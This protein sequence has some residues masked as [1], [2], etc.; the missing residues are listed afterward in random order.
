MS[1]VPLTRRNV[2]EQIMLNLKAL[3]VD[4]AKYE[5]KVG[6]PG[7]K[8]NQKAAIREAR[9][10]AAYKK[11]SK[12]E[13]KKILAA[14]TQNVD[15]AYYAAQNEFGTQSSP[16][17][18]SR[19]F[20]RTTMERYKE[21]INKAVAAILKEVAN[22][23]RDA[24]FFMDKLGQFVAGMVKLNI[25]DGNWAPNSFFTILRKSKRKYSDKPLIDTG[26][27]RQSITSWTVKK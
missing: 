22:N 4:T 9:K 7:G 8:M 24:H 15:I 19:P 16:R 10:S 12:I 11:A 20:L 27:M 6:I 13:R 26:I 14:A 17:I 3:L 2:E 1:V 18:P 25:T 21:K 23:N 5:I